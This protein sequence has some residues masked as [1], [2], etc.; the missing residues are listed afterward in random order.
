MT[1]EATPPNR[2]EKKTYLW[3]LT[4]VTYVLVIVLT[5]GAVWAYYYLDAKVRRERGAPSR[6]NAPELA[7][8]RK[9]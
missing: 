8:R 5:A 9:Q 2:P 7:P 3:T 4:I 6:E 1:E